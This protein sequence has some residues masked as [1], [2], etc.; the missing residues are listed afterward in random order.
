MVMV[1]VLVM[2]M[3]IVMVM[4]MVWLAVWSNIGGRRAKPVS[5]LSAVIINSPTSRPLLSSS[6]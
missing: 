6:L 3:V 1:M 2:V 4:V 5:G